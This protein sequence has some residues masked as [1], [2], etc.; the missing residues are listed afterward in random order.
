MDVKQIINTYV[1]KYFLDGN[2]KVQITNLKNLIKHVFYSNINSNEIDID[3]YIQL[4]NNKKIN[5]MVK[6]IF[7]LKD[8]KVY[9]NSDFFYS[10]A[11]AYCS[12]NGIEFNMES[13]EENDLPNDVD[14]YVTNSKD[15]DIL[16]IFIKEISEYDVLSADETKNLFIQYQNGD[17]ATKKAVSDIIVNHNLRLVLSIRDVELILKI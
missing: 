1:N 10:L 7:S 13:E 15:V 11:M 3:T 9:M 6:S 8:N 16:K 17:E 2:T 12:V 5:N 4:L 14:Y